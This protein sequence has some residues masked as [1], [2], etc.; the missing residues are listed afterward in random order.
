MVAAQS[1]TGVTGLAEG[2][3][4]T[5][6]EYEIRVAGPVPGAVIAE[7]EGCS[8]TAEAVST[9]LYGPV[10]DEAALYGILHR[11]YALGLHLIEVRQLPDGSATQPLP[12]ESVR[13]PPVQDRSGLYRGPL[14]PVKRARP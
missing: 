11:L 8:V 14:P 9:R 13:V 3:A 7:W 5:G 2:V 10:P 6:I 1:G 12:D 4:V